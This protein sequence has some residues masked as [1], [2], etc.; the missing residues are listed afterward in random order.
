[1]DEIF[2]RKSSNITTIVLNAPE[3]RNALNYE[4]WKE[5]AVILD[6]VKRDKS[7]RVLIIRGSGDLAFSSGA[8]INEF[9]KI[10]ANAIQAKKYNIVVE[11]AITDLEC[12]PIP[13]I[14]MIDGDCIGGGCELS[15]ATDIRIASYKSRFGIPAAKLGIAI[16]YQELKLLVSLVGIANAKLILFSGNLFSAEEAYRMGL[17]TLL[18][19]STELEQYTYQ[20][21]ESVAKLAPLSHQTHKEMFRLLFSNIEGSVLA[22]KKEFLFSIFDSKDYFR[23]IEAFKKKTKPNFIGD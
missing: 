10:R 22:N 9:E 16:G 21:S 6:K 11:K 14:S 5:F 1:M 3:R 20:L 8:D 12:F 18:V 15:L 23:G 13:T 7:T 17:L 19:D 2:T 4:M